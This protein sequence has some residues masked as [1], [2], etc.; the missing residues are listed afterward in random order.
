MVYLG[1]LF[2][3][4]KR[5]DSSHDCKNRF[6]DSTGYAVSLVRCSLQCGSLPNQKQICHIG[7]KFKMVV[8][9][10]LVMSVVKQVPQT[11]IELATLSASTIRRTVPTLNTSSKCSLTACFD[12][13]NFVV[14]VFL[15]TEGF[16]FSV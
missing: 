4:V 10:V 9:S 12:Q 13:Y 11:K 7:E 16:Y 1:D 14:V 8:A 6:G 15:V 3:S 5:A 2:S